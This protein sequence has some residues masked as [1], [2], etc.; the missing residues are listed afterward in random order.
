MESNLPAKT[1]NHSK[2]NHL[3]A[4]ALDE[5]RDQIR[6]LRRSQWV[7]FL[8][9]PFQGLCGPAFLLRRDVMP[10]AF[11]NNPYKDP[12]GIPMGTCGPDRGSDEVD[13]ACLGVTEPPCSRSLLIE[14]Q[15]PTQTLEVFKLDV[16]D[17]GWLT[18]EISP[19]ST[20]AESWRPPKVPPRVLVVRF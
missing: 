2:G 20:S 8:A 15:E 19:V 17:C 5:T 9:M 4:D 14:W 6:C 10:E 12:D 11:A 18:P 7:G 3:C 13:P 16:R 1:A